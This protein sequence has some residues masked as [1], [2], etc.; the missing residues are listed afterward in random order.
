MT[1]LLY[2]SGDTELAKRTL[3][4]YVQVVSK[5]YI[6][7]HGNASGITL[8]EDHDTDARWVETL[9]QGARMLC[10]LSMAE[11]GISGVQDAKQAGVLLEKAK[12][13][14]DKENVELV[15]SVK[16]AEGIW[17]RVMAFKGECYIPSLRG[18]ILMPFQNKTHVP[19]QG[20]Y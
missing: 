1:R 11:T 12:E 4:L 16:L 9:V 10:R 2:V 15:A 8:N 20:V 7:G 13:R 18:S 3:Q 19:D 5:A 6:S 14:L 17:N